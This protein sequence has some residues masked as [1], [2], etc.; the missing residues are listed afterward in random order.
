MPEKN[1][2]AARDKAVLLGAY[3]FV[4]CTM[5]IA[6]IVICA[7]SVYAVSVLDRNDVVRQID[8]NVNA[9]TAYLEQGTETGERVKKEF[10]DEYRTKTS[11]VS[12]M[13]TDAEALSENESV[14]EEIRVAVDA[15]EV[16]VFSHDGSVVATTATYGSNVSIAQEFLEHIKD[17]NY[18]NAV[19]YEDERKP[20]VAAAAQ[21]ADKG[22]LLQITYD[23]QPLMSLV[24]DSS[25]SSVA[26]NFPL[27]TDGDTVLIDHES[28][29]YV[30]HTDRSKIGT[31]CSLSKELFRRNKSKFDAGL[32]GESVMIRY[33]KYEDYIIAAF[34]PYDDIF[35]ASYAVL[36]WMIGG[37]IVILTVTA[38]AMRMAT[39]RAMRKYETETDERSADEEPADELKVTQVS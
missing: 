23:A 24:E 29:T 11:V 33:H 3:K 19:L 9:I 38:L 8:T 6:Y 16:S 25:V 20:Y 18:S 2:E 32:S 30:S 37:G 4:F 5:V 17:T 31:E 22:Y 10:I 35:G 15:E 26:R 36:G 34:V 7:L 39:I 12:V 28:F 1:T 21:L 13:I 14:L 27:Y